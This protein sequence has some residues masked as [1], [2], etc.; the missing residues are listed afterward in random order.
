MRKL[1]L[2][3]IFTYFSA[4]CI[5]QTYKYL[6][7]EDGL[8]NRRVYAIQKGPKGYMWF[9]THN[10]IDRYDGKNFKQYRLID[11]EIEVNSM[12]NLSWLY[13]GTDGTL[14]EIGKKGRVFRYDAKHDRFQL[15]YKLPDEV[16]KGT[17]TPV[18]YGFI[19]SNNVIWLCNEEALYLYDTKT[20]KTTIIKNHIGESI[21]D[22]EQIDSEHYFIGTD[23][24]IHHAEL[25]NN[26]LNLSPCNWLDNLK[27]QVNELFLH[28]ES[29]KLFIGT[30]QK[31]VYL[32]DMNIHQA[33][34]LNVGLKDVSI[35]RIKAFNDK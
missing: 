26:V 7:V 24:G 9:L 12:L 10:G 15:V 35:T 13:V 34:E 8:S 32:Y 31:G 30:F 25:K 6:G 19:D 21:T 20:E 5:A 23:V 16:V 11:S 27:M 1:V 2:F 18:S 33:I 22:I 3:F 28:K 14:W 4:L 29:R 17:P